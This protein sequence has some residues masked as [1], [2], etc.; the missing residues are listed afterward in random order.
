MKEIFC[1]Q[2]G[3]HDVVVGERRSVAGVRK[4]IPAQKGLGRFLEKHTR[5]PVV[6][7]VRRID[8]ANALATEVDDLSVG[9]LA[10]RPVTQV[11]ERDH[12]SERAMR[13]FGLRCD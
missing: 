5:L 3:T 2:G 11:I 1:G 12:A 6:R 10:W 9:Q 7:N 8:M 4:K 13:D